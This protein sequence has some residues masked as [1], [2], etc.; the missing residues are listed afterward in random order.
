MKKCLP[1]FKRL[2]L[3]IIHSTGDAGKAADLAVLYATH[4]I[5]ACVK[6]FEPQMQIAWRAADAFVGRSGAATIAE[7][8]EFEV[9][10]IL[11]PYPFATD[12]HQEKNADFLVETVKSGRKL[13]EPGLTPQLLSET[14][15]HLFEDTQYLAFKKSLNVYKKRPH[16]L[17]LCQLVLKLEDLIN[18]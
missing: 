3:Q 2:S 14:L 12:H 17:T 10:G 8:I 18:S 6:A 11:I 4:H 13:L 16:Q 5:P 7:S 1:V 15:E 9:P